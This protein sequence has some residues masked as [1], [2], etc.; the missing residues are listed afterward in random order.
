MLVTMMR[1]VH[2]TV[3]EA[4]GLTTIVTSI[5]AG[6]SETTTQAVGLRTGLIR[7]AT[8]SLLLTAP[9]TGVGV[10]LLP[11]THPIQLPTVP[12]RV[13]P[14]LRPVSLLR[15]LRVPRT[16]TSPRK[17]R[18]SPS[19]SVS[20]PERS[21]RSSTD[22]T[23]VDSGLSPVLDLGLIQRNDV[24]HHLLT[25]H[26]GTARISLQ[27]ELEV[28]TRGGIH[29]EHKRETHTVGEHGMNF[30]ASIAR[31]HTGRW[32]SPGHDFTTLDSDSPRGIPLSHWTRVVLGAH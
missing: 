26:F 2:V 9:T 22:T 15:M 30:N 17:R 23:C 3:A 20:T 29:E 7:P 28:N 12:A 27:D 16:L 13:R 1:V 10:E 25:T 24:E 8:L 11:G 6:V 32:S 19:L 21:E 18:L 4:F 31:Y 14:P 5:L